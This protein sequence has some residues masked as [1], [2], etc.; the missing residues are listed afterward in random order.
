[1]QKSAVTQ[2]HMYVFVCFAYLKCHAQGEHVGPYF[3]AWLPF[4]DAATFFEYGSDRR[5]YW[6]VPSGST[7]ALREKTGIFF[8]GTS[9]RFLPMAFK[10]DFPHPDFFLTT[11]FQL[12]VWSKPT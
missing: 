2:L 3:V 6:R 8:C 10:I 1:M 4:D 9:A 12:C 11:T 7:Q 5:L